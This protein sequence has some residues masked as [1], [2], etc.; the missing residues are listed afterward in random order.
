MSVFVSQYV[1]ACVLLCLFIPVCFCMCVS[2][3][4][5]YNVCVCVRALLF[6]VRFHC[7]DWRFALA[8]K[9]KNC[10]FFSWWISIFQAFNFEQIKV[11]HIHL[12]MLLGIWMDRRRR[13]R[14]RRRRHQQPFIR[15]RQRCCPESC[16]SNGSYSTFMGSPYLARSIST[17][18]FVLFYI[19]CKLWIAII[20]MHVC[21]SLYQF[22]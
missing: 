22:L 4:Y 19:S 2:Y 18:S 14:R 10:F 17:S 1:C 15:H 6:S 13:R 20:C 3:T 9:M 16:V 12:Y 21:Q 8:W 7:F 5:K 11:K